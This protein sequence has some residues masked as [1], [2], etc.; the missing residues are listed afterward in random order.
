VLHL[1]QYAGKKGNWPGRSP[2]MTICMGGTSR[3]ITPACR[4]Y[5]R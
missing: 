5:G 1:W 3:L 2:A 4:I